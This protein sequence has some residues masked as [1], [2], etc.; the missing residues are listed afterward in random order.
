M[1]HRS[2]TI[3]A[4]HHDDEIPPFIRRERPVTDYSVMSLI[5]PSSI[6]HTQTNL[7]NDSPHIH[8][9]LPVFYS[10]FS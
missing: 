4:F 9:M 2:P 8:Q 1:W 3:R 10:I 5:I 7:R 6:S